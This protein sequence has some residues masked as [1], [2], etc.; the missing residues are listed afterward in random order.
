MLAGQ[1]RTHDPTFHLLLRGTEMSENN[2]KGTAE[3]F[4]LRLQLETTLLV[5]V[6]TS[7]ALMGFGF[8][9]CRFGLFLREIASVGNLHLKPHPR[10]A[11]ANTVSGTVMIV[12]GVVVLVLSVYNHLR[13]VS[14]L[15]RGELSLPSRWSLGVILSFFLVALGMAM[16]VYLTLVGS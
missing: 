16:A 7:L 13:L 5:W 12:L 4:K 8:V 1:E 10:L 6:R 9:I 11:L 3:E 2:G 15:E 14:Q